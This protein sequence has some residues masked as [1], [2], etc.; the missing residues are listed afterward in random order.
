MFLF[1]TGVIRDW[2]DIEQEVQRLFE[3]IG[4][5]QLVCVKFDERKLAY[6]IRRR[7][8]GTYVLTYFEAEPERIADLERDARL[9]EVVLR[10]LVLRAE[11]LTEE[12]LAELKAHPAET[13]LAPQT[14]DGR[15]HDDDRRDRRGGRDFRSSGDRRE[16]PSRDEKRTASD[17]SDEKNALAGPAERPSEKE[18]PAT[19]ASLSDG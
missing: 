8:R 12:R 2:S 13:P 10:L 18:S 6:E 11:D 16:G 4:A 5:K 14:G 15:R 7:K 17:D 3:R 19:P 9:S 1:D